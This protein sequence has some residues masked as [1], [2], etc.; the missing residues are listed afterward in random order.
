MFPAEKQVPFFNIFS[1]DLYSDLKR[2]GS[3]AHLNALQ[4]A[5]LKVVKILYLTIKN[6][7][8]VLLCI[9]SLNRRLAMLSTVTSIC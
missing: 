4:T 1:V 5:R 6:V 3:I 2:S 8:K 9:M 7:K